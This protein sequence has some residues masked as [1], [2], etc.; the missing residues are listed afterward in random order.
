MWLKGEL[1]VSR[2]GGYCGKQRM[3]KPAP[4]AKKIPGKF[5]G[6]KKK[7]LFNIS[8]LYLLFAHLLK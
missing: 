3:H 5:A 1:L 7:F 4:G 8:I 2:V 6:D